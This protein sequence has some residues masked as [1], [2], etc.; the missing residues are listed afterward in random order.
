MPVQSG[1]RQACRHAARHQCAVAQ[2]IDDL[3]EIEA[4]EPISHSSHGRVRDADGKA[5]LPAS[6]LQTPASLPE[7]GTGSSRIEARSTLK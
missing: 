1:L 6:V 7:D 5:P 3:P 4:L 2:R